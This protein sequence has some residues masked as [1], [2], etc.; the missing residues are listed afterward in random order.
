MAELRRTRTLAELAAMARGSDE[1]VAD[2]ARRA[3]R[4]GMDAAARALQV[5]PD[6]DILARLGVRPAPGP[7]RQAWDGAVGAIAGYRLRWGP[8]PVPGG[9]GVAW[10]IGA[11][12]T[13]A[14][15]RHYD[16]VA[17]ALAHADR[18]LATTRPTAELAH[19]RR[20]LART[21]AAGPAPVHHDDALSSA[22]VA[23]ERLAQ[24]R[25]AHEHARDRLAALERG[26]RRNRQGVE[27]ARRS[28]VQAER[29]LAAAALAAQQADERAA[30]VG[31]DVEAQAPVRERLALV[32]HALAAQVAVAVARPAPYL[33]AALGPRPADG[34]SER[35]D[36]AAER[37]ES[38]RHRELGLSPADGALPHDDPL[39]R[40]IGARPDE[41]Y[42][43]ARA[44]DEAAHT[45]DPDIDL[46]MAMAPEPPALTFD[47]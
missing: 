20:H 18:E 4:Q 24:A 39:G 3:Y 28:L 27:F 23:H 7:A 47:L 41:D 31:A 8:E 5:D 6:P 36:R 19:E 33:E 43:A 12:P 35:W 46:A 2:L 14:A 38:Y 34:G 40:A 13:G 42:M 37:I 1:R 16:T 10:A 9:A 30:A 25:G 45:L 21:L 15:E 17:A 22:A 29:N 26:R 11:R 44:W 32:D